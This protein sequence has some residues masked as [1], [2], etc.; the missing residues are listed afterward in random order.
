M[1][2]IR[3]LDLLKNKSEFRSRD[4]INELARCGAGVA[5]LVVPVDCV[6]EERASP[7]NPKGVRTPL[8]WLSAKLPNAVAPRSL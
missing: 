4:A 1:H 3:N 6:S 7:P 2:I 8:A 5:V